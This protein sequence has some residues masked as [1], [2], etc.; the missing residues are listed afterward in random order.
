MTGKNGKRAFAAVAIAAVVVSVG[1]L[2]F[3]GIEENLVY[4]W[5]PSD[6][7][8]KSETVKGATIRL[9]G[10]VQEGSMAWNEQSLRLQFS[11][12]E[13]PDPDDDSITVVS[14]G[15][16]PQMFRE[17]IGCVV[18]GRFDGKIFHS[19]RLMVK[20]SNEYVPPSHGEEAKEKYKTLIA[21]PDGAGGATL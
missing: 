2:A 5:T 19:D 6:L 10:M 4:Y 12:G 20:H 9:G 18:E 8:A 7:I 14:T 3:G 13:G 15:A 11:M 1:Y 16:P 21:E 17:G